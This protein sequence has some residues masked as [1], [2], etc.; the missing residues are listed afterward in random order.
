MSGGADWTEEAPRPTGEATQK[1]PSTSERSEDD[2]ER[3]TV[4]QIAIVTITK[5]DPAGIRKTVASVE[6]QDFP[7][8]EHVV[9]DGG[10]DAGVADFLASWEKAASHHRTLVNDPP[11]GIYPAMNRG[12]ESTTAPIV[13][14]L[15]GG[16]ELVPGALRR[17]SEHYELHTWRWAYG[18]LQG[19]NEEG[20]L[21][22]GCSAS[23]FSRRAL[24]AGLKPIPHQ[25]A[26][27]TRELYQDLGL[28]REDLGT[29]ADQEFFLRVSRSSEP[30]LIPGILAIVETWGVSSEETF[31]GREVTWH[32]LRGASG[33]SF[34]GR[35]ATDAVV[36]V[37]LLG[38]LFLIRIIPKLRRIV[39]QANAT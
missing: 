2:L 14:I 8:Y 10:S 25:A 18:G 35:S 28:Y 22:P 32:R 39:S 15:N 6:Q 19:R 36:T 23:R 33:T 7:Y 29:A 34:G 4:A 26:Y 30:A 37:A 16:D 20:L 3:P 13:V 31:I 5:D 21:Q 38:R 12:I 24:R 27:V 9:V 11:A 1:D 17:V